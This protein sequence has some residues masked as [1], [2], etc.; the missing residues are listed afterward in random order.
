M[1]TTVFILILA[2][3][4]QEAVIPLNLVLLIL[5]CRSFI[6]PGRVN[7][8]LAFA[9]G[10]FTAY[11][12]LNNLGFQS[13]IFLLILQL[14][15]GISKTRF[16]S[17]HSLL[18]VPL[19]FILLSANALAFSLI[20]QQSVQFSPKI[21]IESLLALPILFSL[22]LWEERFITKKDIKLRF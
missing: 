16:F 15:Q 21:L 9:F 4:L 17:T 14:T 6:S 2:A 11:L 19:T 5:I 10:M 1:R 18:I 7:L 3:F 22:K 20:N 12:T 13:F 8:F